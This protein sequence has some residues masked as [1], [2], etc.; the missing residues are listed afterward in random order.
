MIPSEDP[1]KDQPDRAEL[2]PSLLKTAS[3]GSPGTSGTG[4]PIQRWGD[5]VLLERIGAGARGEVWRAWDPSLQREVALKFL[6]ATSR[7]ESP[8][9]ESELWN[10][11]RAVARIRHR[12]VVAIYGIATHDHRAGM[13]ME[14]LQGPTLSRE[15]ERLGGLPAGQVTDIGLQLCSALEALEAAGLVHRDIKPSNIVLEN[16]GRVVLTDFGL[17]WRPGL[18]DAERW[19]IS[20][21]PLFMAPEVLAGDAAT[22][23]SDLFSLGV[24]LWWC[25]AGKP[26]FRGGTLG[27]LREAAT[28]GPIE[29]LSRLRPD[30]PSHLIQA[31]EWAMR[32]NPDGRPASAAALA[33]RLHS[34][35][36]AVSRERKMPRSHLG[37]WIGGAAIAVAALAS[38]FL[39]TPLRRV[40]APG[41]AQ[42]WNARKL[43]IPPEALDNS[44]GEVAISPDGT[45]AAYLPDLATISV[46]SL[47]TNESRVIER[48]E[49]DEGAYTTIDWT[50]DGA[51]MIATRC[52]HAGE[53]TAVLIDAVTGEHQ[54]IAQLGRLGLAQSLDVKISLSPNRTL[55]AVRRDYRPREGLFGALDLLDLR[56]GTERSLVRAMPSHIGPPA[57]AP[58]S[59]R[60]A[61]TLAEGDEEHSRIE[62]CDVSGRRATAFQDSTLNL[63]PF[64][65]PYRTVRWAANDR[66]IVTARPGIRGTANAELLEVPIDPRGRRRSSSA[67]QIYAM[68]GASISSPSISSDG[69]RIAFLTDRQNREMKFVGTDSR[70]RFENLANRPQMMGLEFPVWTRDGSGL[71]VRSEGGFQGAAIG[72]VRLSDGRFE[73]LLPTASDSDRPLTVTKDESEL[74]CIIGHSLMAVP[75]SGG[76]PRTIADPF[77]GVVLCPRNSTACLAI[78]HVGDSLLVRDFN[79]SSGLGS[80]RFSYS[81]KGLEEGTRPNVAISPDGAHIALL[82][83]EA[84]GYVILDA[85]HGREEGRVEFPDRSFPQSVQ[86]AADGA[87][88]YATGMDRLAPYWIAHCTL[89]GYDR[90]LWRDDLV[91]PGQLALS[92]DGSTLAFTGLSFGKE[93][94]M[95]EHP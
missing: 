46:L 47:A 31:I 22:A 16:D 38:L 56:T 49:P 37:R 1:P 32:P 70:P 27:E 54:V 12:G 86:W 28:R 41:Q 82:R 44:R 66:L 45:K 52:D 48:L 59:N 39:F 90:L 25:L 60:I 42:S 20:G 23:R 34:P 7:A 92:P 91:W 62:T 74:L 50:T 71:F 51:K 95:I 2:D 57:W 87:S 11:A 33:A 63:E 68:P 18:D 3:L 30:A 80:I 8:E 94:W 78:Q 43:N 14:R 67:K 75:V 77:T 6:Q 89:R 88:L 65:V 79:A 24:T 15:I 10:E 13:W 61:Y 35:E 40:V 4:S 17:G 53:A 19:G 29:D 58:A 85:R 9:P 76:K 72:R 5:L 84:S 55:L 64:G 73:P 21:T 93:M 36:R 81:V 26:P 69:T 83:P